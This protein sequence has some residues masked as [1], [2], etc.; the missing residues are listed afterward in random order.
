MSQANMIKYH[1]NEDILDYY[2]IGQIV[3]T[4][5]QEIREC[6]NINTK[7]IYAVKSLN[8]VNLDLT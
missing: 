8:K 4:Y 5:P 1:V 2:K 3:C 7:L 6:I